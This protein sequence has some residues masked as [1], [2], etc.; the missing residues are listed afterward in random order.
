MLRLQNG[1]PIII[2]KNTNR[3]M[4]NAFELFESRIS[5]SLD[6]C[7]VFE[8]LNKTSY[9]AS[10]LNDVGEMPLHVALQY[11]NITFDIVSRLV[12][13]CPKAVQVACSNNGNLPLHI[14][15]SRGSDCHTDAKIVRLLIV[16]F[17]E[18]A[19]ISNMP[20]KCFIRPQ[21]PIEIAMRVKNHVVFDILWSLAS[22]S[23]KLEIRSQW[24]ASVPK[25]DLQY[26]YK[27][28]NTLLHHV[29]WAHK[30]SEH[31]IFILE[32]Y[33][34]A[35]WIL[36]DEGLCPLDVAL[37]QSYPSEVAVRS[38][39]RQMTLMPIVVSSK[40]VK[41][42]AGETT[43]RDEGA[44]AV[45]ERPRLLCKRELKLWQVLNWRARRNAFLVAA[46]VFK[47]AHF[48]VLS[49]IAAYL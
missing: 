10:V 34:A 15:C 33:P 4:A 1:L 24:M 17:P 21:R 48:Q 25:G 11:H 47:G 2:S 22:E 23:M 28:G 16:N 40:K 14:Y 3:N 8:R 32:L 12:D 44:A 35:V 7:A 39:L 45:R 36:N 20:N 41:C 31:V 13:L 37:L 43:C 30:V 9:N 27:N 6:V 18:A 19:E 38:I 46:R 42:T 29:L 5:R 49:Q 26:R